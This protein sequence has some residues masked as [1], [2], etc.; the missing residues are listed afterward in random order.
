[1]KKISYE[2]DT[3]FISVY[4]SLC[5]LANQVL[6]RD[7][8]LPHYINAQ[9]DF[10]MKRLTPLFLFLFIPT[11]FIVGCSETENSITETTSE[12]RQPQIDPTKIAVIPD[13]NLAKSIREAL[14]L[15]EDVDITA[16]QLATLEELDCLFYPDPD[17]WTDLTIFRPIR[18]WTGLEYA[19]Q[20]ERL[21]LKLCLLVG[22]ARTGESIWDKDKEAADLT[23]LVGLKNLHLDLSTNAIKDLTPLR[24]LKNLKGL[25]LTDN[26]IETITPLAELKQLTHLT[27]NYYDWGPWNE[28]INDLTPLSGLKQLTELAVTGYFDD[29]TPLSGLK[30]LTELRINGI[31]EDLTPLTELKQ[32][33]SLRLMLRGTDFTPLAELKQLTWLDLTWNEISDITSLAELKQLT[34]LN[35]DN[36][37]ISDVTPLA[38]LINLES[39]FLRGNPIVDKTPLEE[40]RKKN[41]KVKIYILHSAVHEYWVYGNFDAQIGMFFDLA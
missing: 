31:F 39:L 34:G 37:E 4:Q 30:Q 7:A 29:L 18:D 13:E 20:L 36:N 33:T 5:T 15:P 38:G 10:T 8:K 14:D 23:P 17:V 40:L 21:N 24:V 6:R 35:L 32:L 11:L 1:M 19:I 27:I 9:G 26:K 22:N 25:N 16:G 3:I 41:P 28:N 12:T 2:T